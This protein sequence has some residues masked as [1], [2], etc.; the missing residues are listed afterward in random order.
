MTF[1]F[2]DVGQAVL[3]SYS[4]ILESLAYT[5]LS[6]IEDVL[7]ADHLARN[8]SQA[9]GKRNQLRNPS[10]AT[11][12]ERFSTPREET[13]KVHSAETPTSMTLSDFMGWDL[14]QG[15]ADLKEPK[16]DDPLLKDPDGKQ[17]IS[18]AVTNKKVSYIEKLEHTGLRSPTARD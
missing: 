1:L 6:R 12:T 18:N 15:D 2:Q 16:G 14:D 5:V 13:E 11:D 10:P 4:R 9:L 7:H 17:K 8:P 3:E